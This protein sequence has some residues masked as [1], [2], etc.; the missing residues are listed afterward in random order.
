MQ[1]LHSDQKDLIA[2]YRQMQNAMV[3]ADTIFRTFT[4]GGS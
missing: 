4:G 1:Q 3:S 2:I